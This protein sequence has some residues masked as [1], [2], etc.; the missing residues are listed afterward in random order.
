MLSPIR[1]RTT[2]PPKFQHP[3]HFFS[4]PEAGSDACMRI[5]TTLASECTALSAPARAVYSGCSR[6]ARP[7]S[8]PPPAPGALALAAAWSASTGAGTRCTGSTG[9][10][11]TAS[12]PAPPTRPRPRRARIAV[13]K[14]FLRGVCGG[15]R[16]CHG[17]LETPWGTCSAW[18]VQTPRAAEDSRGV[19]ANESLCMDCSGSDETRSTTN[20]PT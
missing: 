2:L 10:A 11:T 5:R 12:P 17:C 4:D 19:A 9:P 14:G 13:A 8:P 3:L 18:S 1:P 20:I 16:R 15:G 7:P 6:R